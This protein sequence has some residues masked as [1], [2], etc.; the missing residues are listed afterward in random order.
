[1]RFSRILVAVFFC[2]GITLLGIMVWQVGLHGF[3]E[4]LQTIGLWLVP[5]LLLEAVP[6]GLHTAGW[7]ACFQGHLPLRWW[8]LF[9]V[10][11]AG[12][13][14]N[15]VTP[16]A[17]MGGEV[18]R[19][20]LLE[21]VLPRAQA[22]APVVIGK[23]SVTMAQ[24][25]YVSWGTLYLMWRIP[26][27]APLQWTLSLTT[28]LIGCGLLGFVI[29]QRY[30]LF[31]KLLYAIAKLQIRV[32]PVHWLAPYLALLDAQLVAYYT[33][34]RQRFL[35]SLLLHGLGFASDGVKTYLV[36]RVLLGTQAPSP[37]EA[38]MVAVAVAALDQMFFFV[39]GRLGTLEGVRYT[40]LSTLGGAQIYGLAFGL[41]ARI[42]HL[43]W[44]GIGL[45]AYALCTHCPWVLRSRPTPASAPTA[46][47]TTQRSVEP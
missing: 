22:V 27:P 40:V 3:T 9:L 47:T 45:G 11:Q 8:Q 35:C 24:M 46:I 34:S 26:L 16:T 19:A 38:L 44:S 6:Q 29:L 23:A 18:V 20:L 43:V 7:A 32:Q 28:G 37:A 17:N 15:Q 14:I 1:M 5:F 2:G 10:R 41:I 36:L 25:I 13:A 42:E 39:P 12:T 4:S 21:S 31:S 33:T 30:G